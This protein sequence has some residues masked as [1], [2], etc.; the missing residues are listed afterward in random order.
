MFFDRVNYDFSTNLSKIPHLHNQNT[1]DTWNLS[2]KIWSCK[3]VFTLCLLYCLH[4]FTF[5][6]LLFSNAIL[7]VSVDRGYNYRGLQSL[8]LPW[9]LYILN[10]ILNQCLNDTLCNVHVLKRGRCTRPIYFNYVRWIGTLQSHHITSHYITSHHS[11]R[12]KG[13]GTKIVFLLLN[14]TSIGDSIWLTK[15]SYFHNSCC[16]SRQTSL[17]ALKDVVIAGLWGNSSNRNNR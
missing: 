17:P 7:I 14:V 6:Y 16:H 13:A 11:T 3:R 12:F 15:I 9:F 1:F 8:L 5:E 2:N 10:Y 4:K